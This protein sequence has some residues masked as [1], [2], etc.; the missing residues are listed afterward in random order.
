MATGTDDVRLITEAATSYGYADLKP[1]QTK[2]LKSFVEGKDVFV[3]L[4]TVYSKS[5]C[6][7]LLPL[8]FNTKKGLTEKTS[9][10]L[11]VSPL[12]A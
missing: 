2:V 10:C 8:I 7:A 11:I 1:E 5:L 3:S 4:P 6:Y 12:I 9:I